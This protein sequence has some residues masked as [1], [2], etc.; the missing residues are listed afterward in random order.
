MALLRSSSDDSVAKITD[1]YKNDSKEAESELVQFE[2]AMQKGK[3][4][5]L[6]RCNRTSENKK[7]LDEG[8]SALRMYVT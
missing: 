3:R 4:R 2:S 1:F 6:S 8:L 5:A 7:S